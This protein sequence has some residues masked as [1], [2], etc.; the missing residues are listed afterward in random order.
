MANTKNLNALYFRPLQLIF[1][2]IKTTMLF[3]LNDE[4]VTRK[5]CIL[6]FNK[7]YHEF[8]I[9]LVANSVKET[10]AQSIVGTNFVVSQ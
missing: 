7:K 5:N 8:C 9:S 4:A 10:A 2:L 3:F 6:L 1:V